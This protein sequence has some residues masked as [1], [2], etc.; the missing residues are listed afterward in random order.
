MVRTKVST[1]IRRRCRVRLN[2]DS[3]Q[4]TVVETI[5]NLYGQGIYGG[6]RYGINNEVL[7]KLREVSEKFLE[8][9]WDRVKNITLQDNR[10][11]VLKKDFE[12]WKS[13]TGFQRNTSKCSVR[14]L[15]KLFE[16]VKNSKRNRLTCVKRGRE[17]DH[18]TEH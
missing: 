3:F 11:V 17:P 18:G 14:S 7:D 16:S 12:T 8:N 2:P 10:S 13:E 1:K 5:I 6:L 9:M 4:R 15:C